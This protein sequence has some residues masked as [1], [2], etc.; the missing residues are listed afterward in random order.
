MLRLAIAVRLNLSDRNERFITGWNRAVGPH[1]DNTYTRYRRV[2]KIY[3]WMHWLPGGAHRRVSRSD[4]RSC[5]KD[6]SS[7]TPVNARP[8]SPI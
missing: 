6:V 8:W 7:R 5:Y 4:D 1:R 2:L 3:T